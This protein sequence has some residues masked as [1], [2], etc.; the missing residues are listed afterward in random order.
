MPQTFVCWSKNLHEGCHNKRCIFYLCFSLTK[1]W[2]T[3]P[4]EIPSNYQKFKDVFEKRNAN[5]L[6]KHPPYD[7]TIDL[8][9]GVQPPLGL[10]YNLKQYELPMFCEYLDENFNKGFIWHSKS[11]ASA[12]ILFV[13]F[14]NMVICE[15]VDYCGLNRLTI[16][17]W[18]PLPLISRLLNQLNHAKVYTKI[19]LHGAYNFIHIR[20]GNEWK[21]VFRTRYGH[22]EYVVMPFHLTNALVIFPHLMNNVF[23]EYLDDFMVCYINDIFIF[24]K[25][26]EDH[27]HHVRHACL[28]LEKL[29]EVELYAKLEKC[30]FHQFKVEFLGYVI[31]GDGIRM[32][33][34]KVQNHCWLGYSNFCSKC[35]IFSWICQLLLTF[36]CPL[37]FNNGPSYSID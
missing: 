3:H 18:Y 8:V 17:N 27:E 6:P 31:F 34:C 29:W 21:V 1:C 36:H 22:F 28:V 24:S 32:D 9:E 13:N 35:W 7:C 14:K 10:I 20:E 5:T 12:L 30:E 33:P 19:D 15:C 25:N 16:K 11:Q 2:T 23:H 37:F 4:H 26:M